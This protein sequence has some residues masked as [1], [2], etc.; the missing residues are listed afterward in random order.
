MTPKIIFKNLDYICYKSVELQ[1]NLKHFKLWK[2]FY[3]KHDKATLCAKN[4]SVQT[5]WTQGQKTYWEQ[6]LIIERKTSLDLR[7]TTGQKRSS[8]IGLQATVVK[9]LTV[10]LMTNK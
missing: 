1:K 2:Y 5:Q 6:G 8:I 9:I 7:N 10:V 3:W 4:D